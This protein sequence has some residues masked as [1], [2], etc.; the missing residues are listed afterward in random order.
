MDNPI[1]DTMNDRESFTVTTYLADKERDIRIIRW[2]LK[3]ICLWPHSHNV[4]TVDRVFSKFSRLT[5]FSLLFI[6]VLNIGLGTF[7]EEREDTIL[8][9]MNI[10][11]FIGHL[12]ALL[13]YICLVLHI[14]DIRNC[15]DSIE[16]HW[17]T[18]RSN[19]DHEVMLKD[20]KVGRFMATFIATF[21][22]GAVQSYNISKCFMKNVVDVDNVSVSICEL[23]FPSYNEILDTRFRPVYDVVFVMQIIGSFLVSGVT[24]VNCGLMATFVM[25]ACGQLKILI[26]WI[27]DIIHNDNIVDGRTIQE[28]LGFIVEHHLRVLKHGIKTKKKV[29]QRIV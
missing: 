4:S 26:L 16:L 6:A 8:M 24:S 2:L 22:H 5:C 17:N 1:D 13:K 19:K 3:S 12:M 9:M 28:K 18:V 11:P 14:D 27:G 21:M 23:P 10:G 15:V 7:I 25:H 20:A 29:F